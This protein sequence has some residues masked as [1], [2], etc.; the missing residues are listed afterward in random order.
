MQVEF[1][2]EF[3][4]YHSPHIPMPVPCV[5]WISREPVVDAVDYVVDYVVVAPNAK[6]GKA[7]HEVLV[8]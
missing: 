1:S 3:H 8:K 6:T 2:F 5:L 4:Q 7:R